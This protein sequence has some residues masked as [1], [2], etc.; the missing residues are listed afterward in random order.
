MIADR[1]DPTSL[2]FNT[3]VMAAIYDQFDIFRKQATTYAMS[4][5]DIYV[6]L[7]ADAAPLPHH[8]HQ[9]G[10]V[11][12][13]FDCYIFRP[14]HNDGPR[15]SIAVRLHADGIQVRFYTT[16]LP[17]SYYLAELSLERYERII[18]TTSG[19]EVFDRQLC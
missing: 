17:I 1:M 2:P 15:K 4:L 6:E 18:S 14:L 3:M 11:A 12:V 13:G 19:A 9:L 7:H 8:I 5:V 10:P 16:W